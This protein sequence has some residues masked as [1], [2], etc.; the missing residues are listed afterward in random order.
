MKYKRI[1]ALLTAASLLLC[2]CQSAPKTD[3]AVTEQPTAQTDANGEVIPLAEDAL[4]TKVKAETITPPDALGWIYAAAPTANGLLMSDFSTTIYRFEPNADT[5]TETELA[6]LAP[7]DGYY[8]CGGVISIGENGFCRL[9]AMENHN[10]MNPADGGDT[11][12]DFWEEYYKSCVREFWLCTYQTDGTLSGKVSVMGLE[13]YADED[14]NVMPCSLLWDEAGTCLT[15]VDGTILHIGE[16]GSVTKTDDPPAAEN[17]AQSRLITRKFL[18]DR[19]DEIL[20]CETFEE[21]SQ[22]GALSWATTIRAFDI[23]T[24]KA[25]E[26]LLT[27][28]QPFTGNNVD[29]LPGGCEDYRLFVNDGEHL[30][31]LK[32]DGTSETVIDWDASDLDP[33]SVM[34]LADGRFI[35][36]GFGNSGGFQYYLLTRLKAAEASTDLTLTIAVL[37]RDY[38]LKDFVQ[39]Y[40]RSHTNVR[41]ATHS[42]SDSEEKTAIEQLKMDLVTDKAPDIV[43]MYDQHEQVL[44]LGSKG[45]FADLNEFMANDP[46]VSR[47]KMLPNV[48]T[49]MQHPNGSLYALASGFVV[50][51]IAVKTKFS[52]K[53][54]WSVDDMLSLYEGADDI[55]YY[56]STKEEALN[57]FLAGTDFTDELA[58]TCSFD[59]PEFIKILEF[60]NRYPA[61]T[62]CPPKQDGDWSASD[63]WYTEKF[64]SHQRDQDYLYPFAISA[65]GGGYALSEWSY[66]KT[67]LGGDMTLV[68][69][70]SATGQGGKIKQT[71]WPYTQLGEMGIVSTCK[72]PDA[73]W[74]VVRAFTLDSMEYSERPTFS[75]FEDKFREQMDGMMYV[76][77]D[78]K[79]TDQKSVEDDGTVYPLTQEERDDLERYIRNCSTYMMLDSTV[80]NIILEEAGKYFAGD[81]TSD[82]AA[83]AIQSR[84]SLYLAEQN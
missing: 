30:L 66:V 40:N 13:A 44:K 79:P 38:A 37:D 4:T 29:V 23:K 33:M 68:G 36:Y 74:D 7:Y 39:N 6:K 75:L 80:K 83:K 16:D 9:T 31:G 34:P 56:W 17:G 18:R 53:E 2:G 1:A 3:P 76:W 26:V 82:D 8:D 42:Y 24:G 45:V 46:E 20:L 21:T 49:A 12:Y 41:L 5:W 63:N 67:Y 70:P 54:N 77:E 47:D 71:S 73:A 62:T 72:H 64:Y 60:C 27:A 28:S 84:A 81:C 78:G 61:E 57:M 43:V 22:D 58:G 50:D 52:D 48:I 59:N 35:A 14:G 51:T 65:P 15:M 55:V 25:G 11:D 32:N 69:Y 10:N 19:D